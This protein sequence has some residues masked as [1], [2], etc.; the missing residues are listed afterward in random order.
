MEKCDLCLERLQ[1]GKE[2]LCVATCPGEALRF[3]SIE[4][5]VGISAGRPAEKLPVPAGPSFLVSGKM[6]GA[7]FLRILNSIR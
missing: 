2:P 1:Q 7:A 3:G 5:L 6:T 4:N